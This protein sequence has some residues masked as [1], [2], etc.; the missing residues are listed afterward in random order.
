MNNVHTTV[1]VVGAGPTGLLLAGDLAHAGVDVTVLERRD[2]ESNLTR[3]FG[4]HA[5]TLEHLDARGLADEVL[6]QGAHVARLSLFDHLRVDLSSLGTRF[7]IPLITPQYNVEQ[8]LEKRASAGGAR[9][10]RG[11]AVTALRQDADGVQLTVDGAT[12]SADYVVG[13]DGVN[14]AVRDALGLPFP[15]KSVLT[16][17]MLAD[18]RLPTLRRT[19]SRSTRSATPSRSSRP[20]V[21]GGTASSRGTAATRFPTPHQ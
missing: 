6:A 20:S 13:A 8:V 1:A 2:T 19:C 11:A 10:L 16:S 4:V 14:S 3:A 7:P 12:V 9:I 21:T 18:V 15:G 5:R 17:I